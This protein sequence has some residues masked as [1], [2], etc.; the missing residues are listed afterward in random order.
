MIWTPRRHTDADY[1]PGYLAR[2]IEEIKAGGIETEER[3]T[4]TMR[5]RCGR[6]GR[7]ASERLG[8]LKPVGK[9]SKVFVNAED[10]SEFEV[11]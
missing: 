3:G 11:W 8:H 7:K 10:R 9:N 5:Q 4:S 6:M 2:R 1:A